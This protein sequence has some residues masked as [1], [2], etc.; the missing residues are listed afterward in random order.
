MAVE[1]D[2]E[3]VDALKRLDLPD[4][5]VVHGDFLRFDLNTQPLGFKVVGNVPYQI[6]TP[7][8]CYLFGEIGSPKPWFEKI[9]KVVLTVQYEVA[10][11]FVAKPGTSEYSQIT[12]LSNYFSEAEIL[13]VLPPESFYPPPKVTSAVVQFKPLVKP[14]I[15]CTNHKLLRQVIK[16]GFSQ[17]RKMLKNNLSFLK[18]GAAEI[19]Q[20]F[21]ELHLEPQVRAERLSLCEF[22]KLTD[23]L[24]QARVSHG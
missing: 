5:D 20:V 24:E 12:L 22:A 2:G 8:L 23:A 19:D 6:T 4:V 1:L 18:C 13:Y 7:I 16:A 14:P 21:K 10:Q 11:R 9:E 3:C 17:R 15:T